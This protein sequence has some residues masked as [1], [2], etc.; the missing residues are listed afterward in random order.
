VA[1]LCESTPTSFAASHFS[2]HGNALPVVV[3]PVP[4]GG[5]SEEVRPRVIRHVFFDVGRTNIEE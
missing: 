1:A 3:V 4:V 2:Q 5:S